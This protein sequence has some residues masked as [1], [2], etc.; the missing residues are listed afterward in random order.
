LAGVKRILDFGAGQGGPTYVLTR[1]A[2]RIGAE[3]EAVDIGYEETD[4]P[5]RLVRAGTLPAER[6][7]SADGINLLHEKA[8]RKEKYDLITAFWFGPDTNGD[9]ASKFI[10]ASKDAINDDGQLLVTSDYNSVAWVSIALQRA[11][12]Q[13]DLITSWDPRASDAPPILVTSF[14]E[15]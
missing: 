6:V 2:T 10:D 9:L 4:T 15:K 3:V 11:G 12:L 7:Y 5:P 13:R 1:Y 8:D 14:S